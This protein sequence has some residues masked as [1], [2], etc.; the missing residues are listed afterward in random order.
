MFSTASSEDAWIEPRTVATLALTVRH[1]N[2]LAISHPQ[3]GYISSTTRLYLT[4]NSARLDFTH[5]RL[6]LIQN[7]LDPTHARLDL[8]H[9]RIDLNHAWLDLIHSRLDLI[10]ARLD[11]IHSRLDLT[12]ARLDLIHRRLDLTHNSAR[13]HPQSATF[14]HL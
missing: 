10:H 14:H 11:L 12:H 8:I 4:H 2:H 13:S 9:S 5:T 1:S 6:D 3:L 7:R